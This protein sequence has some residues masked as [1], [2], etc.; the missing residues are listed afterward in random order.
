MGHGDFVFPG[1]FQ[2][3][4]VVRQAWDATC[5]TARITG[6]TPHDARHTFGVHAA[7]AGVPIAR[8]QRLMGHATATMTLRYMRH[9]P[10]AYLDE[11]AKAIAAHM[12]RDQ[13]A[14]VPA[15]AV[16]SSIRTA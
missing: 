9:A 7:Q 13:E 10:E 1:A 11:D 16:R 5:N 14:E 8:L 12:K 4:D 2:E 6:A 15:S 3:Y